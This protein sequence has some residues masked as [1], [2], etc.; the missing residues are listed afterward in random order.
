MRHPWFR[1]AYISLKA[2][3]M[4]N[5]VDLVGRDAGLQGSRSNVQD[6][7]CQPADF[8]HLLLRRGVQEVDLVCAQGAAGLGDAIGGVVWVGDRLGHFPLLRERVDRPQGAREGEGREGVVV[9]GLWI[10]FRHYF[11]REE[12][13]EYTG[14]LLVHALMSGLEDGESSANALICICSGAGPVETG[15][16]TQFFLKQSWEQKKLSLMPSFRQVGHCSEPASLGQSTPRHF[17]LAGGSIAM[18]SCKAGGGGVRGAVLRCRGVNKKTSRAPMYGGAGVS[19]EG[20]RS[21]TGIRIGR[22]RFWKGCGMLFSGR[23]QEKRSPRVLR[24]RPDRQLGIDVKAQIEVG[25][26]LTS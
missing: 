15:Q 25:L 17:F 10:R 5:L 14:F 13:V 21:M 1:G 2:G 20:K 3:F 16:L 7:S 23:R 18:A 8:P 19:D 9:A 4:D 24:R 12:V 22:W 26:C 6:F 11:R